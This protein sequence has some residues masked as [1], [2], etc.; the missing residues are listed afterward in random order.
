MAAFP[1]SRF[2]RPM[3]ARNPDLSHR[4]WTGSGG[5]LGKI[6][7]VL[8]FRVSLTSGPLAQT[9]PPAVTQGT[10]LP[11]EAFDGFQ[12]PGAA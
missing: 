2:L 11:I 1:V 5:A 10:T 3:P 7:P 12:K 9:I 4:V 6:L 8:L